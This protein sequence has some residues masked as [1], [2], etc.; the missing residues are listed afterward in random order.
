MTTPSTQ[1]ALGGEDARYV[2]TAQVG[3]NAVLFADAARLYLWPGCRVADVTYGKGVFWQNVDTSAYEFLATD[4]AMGI[5]FRELP[6]EDDSLDAVVLDPPYIYNPKDTVKASISEPYKVNT[7]G[8]GLTTV[9]AVIELYEAGIRE[10]LRVLRPGGR[11]FVKCQDQIQAG[12][13][14][15]VHIELFEFAR[16]LGFYARDLL[17]LVQKTRPAIRW[18]Q[19]KHARKNH[20]Y[21]WVFET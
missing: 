12:K 8:L 7:T 5:D 4:L 1:L 16:S 14:R 17:V 19:Q 3:T 20:S 18:P 10:A 13:Q 2:L 9:T 21:L 11:L 15:W 6:Y